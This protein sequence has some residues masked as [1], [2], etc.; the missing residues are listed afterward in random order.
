M[1][2]QIALG[3]GAQQPNTGLYVFGEWLTPGV[4]TVTIPAGTSTI[5]VD[6]AGGGGGGGAGFAS[7][8]SGGGGGG[9]G[10]ACSARMHPV[11]VSPVTTRLRITVGAAGVAG[12]VGGSA[13]GAGGVT[14]IIDPD[15]PA[16]A[17]TQ[18]MLTIWGAGGT[19]A[20]PGT[21]TNGG[22]GG[23]T[24]NP[25]YANGGAGGASGVAGSGGNTPGVSRSG[26][27]FVGSGGAGG[28]RSSAAGG[29]TNPIMDFQPQSNPGYANGTLGGG[30]A[31]GLTVWAETWI[32]RTGYQGL[33]GGTGIAYGNDCPGT[34]GAGGGCNVPGNP[35]GPG[36]VR[37]YL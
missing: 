31:G 14:T 17:Y 2:N 15:A 10:S 23:G 21:S 8:S 3:S 20:Q 36:F 25:Q 32:G 26:T 34:G 7:A 1:A 16:G 12:V 30:G 28:G 35:G 9:G 13:A 18:N 11:R 6:G 33:Q 19:V 22:Q 37:I 4:Y 29:Q 5:Y 24:S 27:Y